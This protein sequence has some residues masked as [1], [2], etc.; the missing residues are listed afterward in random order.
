[1]LMKFKCFIPV[2]ASFV[3]FGI[4]FWYIFPK[5]EVYSPR[6]LNDVSLLARACLDLHDLD[7]EAPM[8]SEDD[9]FRALLGK[10][11]RG[12][13]LLPQRSG[14]RI[15]MV[16]GDLMGPNNENIDVLFR[17]GQVSIFIYRDKMK[18]PREALSISELKCIVVTITKN[19]SS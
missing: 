7:A 2:F 4:G 10:N 6:F 9:L 3:G 19:Q 1:M 12:L 11:S 15:S 18:Q 8:M 17:K 5:D 14:F 13:I 16:N